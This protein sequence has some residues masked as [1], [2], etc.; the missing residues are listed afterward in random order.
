M[1]K[2]KDGQFWFCSFLCLYLTRSL[3]CE[4]TS[5]TVTQDITTI[6]RGLVQILSAY[7]VP[8]HPCTLLKSTRFALA[9]PPND[10]TEV[11]VEM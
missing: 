10:D 9:A 6:G 11:D 2:I 7:S 1:A 4:L 3:K 8:I 5:C